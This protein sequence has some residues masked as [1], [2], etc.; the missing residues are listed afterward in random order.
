VSL[1]GFVAALSPVAIRK[2]FDA[3]VRRDGAMSGIP[4]NSP[5]W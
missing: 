2:N 5:V 4:R 3:L 1:K